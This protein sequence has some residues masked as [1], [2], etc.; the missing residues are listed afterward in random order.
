MN[1]TGDKAGRRS[2]APCGLPEDDSVVSQPP[3]KHLC[4][5]GRLSS[6]AGVVVWC[7]IDRLRLLWKYLHGLARRRSISTSV[8]PVADQL[9]VKEE[10]TPGGLHLHRGRRHHKFKPE[11]L[12]RPVPGPSVITVEEPSRPP[13]P[14]LVCKFTN[15][16]QSDS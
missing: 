12:R 10:G 16:I 4:L 2:R 5:G 6:G 9:A 3:L 8:I 1:M 15:P 11:P 7:V 14:P 13:T